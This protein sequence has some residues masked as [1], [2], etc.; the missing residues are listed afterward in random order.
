MKF[1]NEEKEL[2]KEYNES[3]MNLSN[4]DEIVSLLFSLN[5]KND[6]WALS[7]EDKTVPL[8]ELIQIKIHFENIGF[9]IAS[10]DKATLDNES[11]RIMLDRI[12]TSK[13]VEHYYSSANTRNKLV[14]LFKLINE[15]HPCYVVMEIHDHEDD[16]KAALDMLSDI[17]YQILYISG[18]HHEEIVV[19]EKPITTAI[20]EEEG[21][22][23]SIEFKKSVRRISEYRV[24]H[25]FNALY[26]L[27]IAVCLLLACIYITNNSIGVGFL[28]LAFNFLFIALIAY[29]LYLYKIDN[30]G[31]TLFDYVLFIGS[32]IIAV[33]FGLVFGWLLASTLVKFGD[34][35][36]DYTLNVKLTIFV[37]IPSL[38]L[39]HIAR[40]IMSEFRNIKKETK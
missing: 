8:S 40:A 1:I 37:S 18:E 29:N 2:I 4:D 20:E 13:T 5:N 34:N 33:G 9:V 12:L 7:L 26:S 3:I 38:I 23:T 14:S 17:N 39:A 22:K 32:S 10:F 31:I 21:N 30:N 35:P 11:R 36:I 27:L 25:F 24:E 6:K 16:A 15:Y 28:F 19:K